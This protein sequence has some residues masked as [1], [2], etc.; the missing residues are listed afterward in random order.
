MTN[1]EFG[2]PRLIEFRRSRLHQMEDARLDAHFVEV[3]GWLEQHPPRLSSVQRRERARHLERLDRYRRRARFPRNRRFPGK[4]VPHFIDDAGTRCAMGHLIELGGGRDLVGR[5]ASERNYARVR[6]LVDLSEL[7]EWLDANGLTLEE[8]ERIQPTYCGPPAQNCLCGTGIDPG[9]VQ[10]ILAD[11]GS[12]L[13]VT[14]VYGSIHGVVPGD[15]L[16]LRDSYGVGTNYDSVFASLGGDGTT[17]Y[18]AFGAR[19]DEVTIP[20]SAC[21][22]PQVASIPGPLPLAV[23]Q[24]ALSSTTEA[25]CE[26][27][28]VGHD[29]AWGVVQGDC[30]QGGSQGS[31]G[32]TSGRDAGT[33]SVK[34]DGGGGAG[35]PRS[36]DGGCSVS[37][38]GHDGGTS[39]GLAVSAAWLFRRVRRSRTRAWPRRRSAHAPFSP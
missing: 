34:H 22:F 16:Q 2:L 1:T 18:V 8:A 36:H 35:A 39:I 3:L 17:A 15:T 37:L 19:G 14:A 12:T 11:G 13:L 7:V 9:Y 4:R 10:G 28:L 29:P 20:T 25:A 23:V 27:V 32:G 6:E 5:I 31:G 38:H 21:W 33:T 24:Q 30:G 26:N